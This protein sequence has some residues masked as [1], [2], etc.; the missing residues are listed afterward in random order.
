VGQIQKT[1]Y[2]AG[3]TLQFL[4]T[5]IKK[6]SYYFAYRCTRYRKRDQKLCKSADYN[7][8][9]ICSCV[10]VYKELSKEKIE[11][12]LIKEQILAYK[13]KYPLTWTYL[14]LDTTSR[15][16]I[17]SVTSKNTTDLGSDKYS[18]PNKIITYLLT[19]LLH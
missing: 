7:R 8:K 9:S 4:P 11:K 3:S 19:Y 5:E 2:I 12:L 6:N 16:E 13:I 18:S 10:R 17:P 1:I 14:V 15:K